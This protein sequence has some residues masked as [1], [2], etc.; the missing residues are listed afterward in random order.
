M[1]KHRDITAVHWQPR[2]G[3]DGDVVEGIDDI[4]QCI[5]T[6][7]LT[8][9]GSDPHRPE[10]GSDIWQYIDWPVD[11]AAPHLVR[12]V[13]LAIERWEPR[14]ILVSVEPAIENA[15]VVLRITWQIAR[16]AM[17]MVTEVRL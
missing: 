9:K 3:A 7:L 17:E 12:E 10:F 15:R 14:A 5:A 16:D 8:R 6:I 2:L 1:I 4:A 11:R 13:T